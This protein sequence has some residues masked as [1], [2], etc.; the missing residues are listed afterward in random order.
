MQQA[1]M[2]PETTLLAMP[3]LPSPPHPPLSSQ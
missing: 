3:R 1:T 2:R